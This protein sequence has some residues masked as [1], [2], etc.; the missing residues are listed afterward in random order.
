M[1][2]DFT[3]DITVNASVTLRESLIE[4]IDTIVEDQRRLQPKYKKRINRSS[5]I[6]ILIDKCL[7]ANMDECESIKLALNNYLESQ[8]NEA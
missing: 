7:E 1:F 3:Q 8:R 4:A 6:N 2:F 5:V